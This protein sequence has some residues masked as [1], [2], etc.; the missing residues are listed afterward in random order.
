MFFCV[1]VCIMLVDQVADDR[2]PKRGVARRTFCPVQTRQLGLIRLNSVYLNNEGKKRKEK[3][4]REQR[5]SQGLHLC[6]QGQALITMA[7]AGTGNRGSGCSW[8]PVLRCD[9]P[10]MA[11]ERT[12]EI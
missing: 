2:T 5:P 12:Q 4:R 3:D 8:R 10:D 11:P 9:L 1:R 7:A 6:P